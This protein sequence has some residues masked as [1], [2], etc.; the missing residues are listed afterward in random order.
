MFGLKGKMTLAKFATIFVTIAGILMAL[1]FSHYLFEENIHY[2]EK[3]Q[4]RGEV[5]EL[6]YEESF[7]E[8]ERAPLGVQ[9]ICT[10]TADK[11]ADES[12][13]F[14]FF[15][16]HQYVDVYIDNKL[17][18][19]LK[20]SEACDIGK[21]VGTNWINIALDDSQSGKE[22][23]VIL[24]PVYKDAVDVDV[25]F[26]QGPQ[27]DLVLDQIRDGLLMSV[28]SL[29]SIFAGIVFIIIA[30]MNFKENSTGGYLISLGCFAIMIGLW[31]FCDLGISSIL[32]PE[33]TVLMFYISMGMLMFAPVPVLK[34]MKSFFSE[35][36]HKLLDI[37]SIVVVAVALLQ[38]L[39]QLLDVADIRETLWMTHVV[40]IINVMLAASSFLYEKIYIRRAGK[41]GIGRLLFLLCAIGATVDLVMFYGQGKAYGLF[42]LLAFLI[43]IVVVG[44]QLA[45]DYFRKQNQL[46]EKEVELAESR[47]DLMVSQ[48]Q[49]HFLYNVIT[50]IMAIC[51]ESSDKAIAALAD[52]SDYLRGNLDSLRNDKMI[53]FSKELHHIESYLRLEKL[54]FPEKLQV[55]YNIGTK[56]FLI[57]TLAV[58]PLIENAV[59]HGIGQKEE[60]GTVKL[61]TEDKGD[62][63]QVIVSDDGVGFDP[64]MKKDDGRSHLGL[65]NVRR[66]IS[67]MSKG[68][69][70]VNTAPGE[71]TEIILTLPKEL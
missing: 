68:E 58:Q 23:K 2:V 59:K 18:Y 17:V 8:N 67:G 70:T 40:I 11:L 6:D 36:L 28:L 65:E 66:R 9:H 54:R 62:H 31:K 1:M 47:I 21:T 39:L 15:A 71:G 64:T 53:S 43:Y 22:I 27:M 57:P 26:V 45:F 12:E 38:L 19:S 35:S 46:L 30:S 25:E 56:D 42:T 29:L 51:M 7:S 61:I 50:S 4:M 69:M 24:T 10:M 20:K 60:G 32:W 3:E 41:I 52:F 14:A 44:F 49:P 63:V 55:E 34:A 48:I 13:S 37:S 5:H 16:T 33:K